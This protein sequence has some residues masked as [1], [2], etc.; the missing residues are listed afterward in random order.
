MSTFKTLMT[1]LVAGV[2]LGEIVATL[3]ASAIIPWWNT[4]GQGQAMCECSK[5]AHDTVTSLISYQLTGA[6]IGGVLFL[7]LGAL[8]VR[9][10]GQR[11]KATTMVGAPPTTP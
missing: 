5:I 6:A 10:R 8:T 11:L 4:P 2:L 9:W 1:F 7:I 3:L